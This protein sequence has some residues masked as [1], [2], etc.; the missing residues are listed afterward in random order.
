MFAT[1]L[2]R[3]DLA[4]DGDPIVTAYS[5]LLPVRMR[6]SQE[7]MLKIALMPEER[8]GASVLAWWGGN[9]A[10]RV[11]AREGDAL[12]LERAQSGPS[13]EQM[14]KDGR[15][16]E[17]TRIIC[18]VSDTLHRKADKPPAGLIP[19]ERRFDSLFA[20]ADTHGGILH[21][22]ADMARELLGSRTDSHVLHGD[23]HHGNILH[24]GPRG[25]L[26]IDPKGIIGERSFEYCCLFG[27][28]DPQSALRPGRLAR[29]ARIVSNAASIDQRRLLKWIFAW[30]GLSAS[31][32]FDD[33][34]AG[35]NSRLELARLAAAGLA[36]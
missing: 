34:A 26:A 19:L 32:M 35:V 8:H 11:I 3:W 10:A 9:G 20:A 27:N 13:L 14:V 12:L 18:A 4:A 28:P 5:R 22:S 36:A 2:Q 16:D 15:D 7:A 29:Q 21:Q 23:L 6:D 30:A 1:Y 17:A 24:F 31:M 33:N 25:W